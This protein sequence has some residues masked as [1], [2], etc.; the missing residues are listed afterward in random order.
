MDP[1]AREQ[2][3][4]AWLDD[5][6]AHYNDAEPRAGLEQRILATVRAEE[7]TPRRRWWV[8]WSPALAAVAAIVIVVIAVRPMWR[9]AQPNTHKP[10]ASLQQE[11][12]RDEKVEA[13]TGTTDKAARSYEMAADKSRTRVEKPGAAEVTTASKNTARAN[14]ERRADE[15]PSSQTSA[16]RTSNMPLER[17]EPARSQALA[18]D[19]DVVT[20]QVPVQQEVPVAAAGGVASQV[21][22]RSVPLPRR[23]SVTSPMMAAKGLPTPMAATSITPE[24]RLMLQAAMNGGLQPAKE[25]MP[26]RDELLPMVK[27]PEIEIEN[28]SE[29]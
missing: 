8:R 18:Q 10:L 3:L 1:K 17:A 6:L 25:Q 19:A 12:R 26:P 5:A 15:I 24:E 28:I 13:T 4:D 21:V 29:K 20:L 14:S 9:L 16:A 27:I 2:K 11:P 23:N 22:A 7:R